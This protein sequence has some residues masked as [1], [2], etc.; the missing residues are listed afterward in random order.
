MDEKVLLVEDDPSVRENASLILERAGMTVTS[1]DDG[2]KALDLFARRP[3]ELVVLDIMLPSVG[4]FE[5][6]RVIRRTS[7][8][9]IIMLTARTDTTDVV[10]G[11]ELGAD[12]YIT[13][14]FS[15]AELVARRGP[16]SVGP[17]STT[18]PRRCARE[19]WR[20]T[21]RASGFRGPARRST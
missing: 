11:L 7:Q 10:V 18:P 9:P 16:P 6:C 5:V 3:F 4:G 15:D 14:P 19:S 8:T 20:S 2:R 1:V 17:R 12:D 13:K 21:Q